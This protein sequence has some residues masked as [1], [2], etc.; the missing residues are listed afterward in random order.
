[1]FVYAL[2]PRTSLDETIR[3]QAKKVAEEHL[4]R[5]SHTMLLENQQVSDDERKKMLN[6]KVEDL[7]RDMPKD[8]WSVKS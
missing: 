8:F 7:M 2:V 1:V 6:A 3:A 5:T 4:S